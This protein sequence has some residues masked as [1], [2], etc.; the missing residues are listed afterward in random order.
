[1]VLLNSQM[2]FRKDARSSLFY[3]EFRYCIAWHIKHAHMLRVLNTAQIQQ[4]IHYRNGTTR[5][6][7][8]NSPVTEDQ[9]QTLLEACDYLNSRLNPYRKNVSTSHVWFYTNHPADF[10]RL[11]SFEGSRIESGTEA[12]VCLEPGVVTLTRPQHEYRTYFKERWLGSDQLSTIIR[13][14][15]SRATQFRLSPGFRMLV[16]GQRIWMT[17]N[18]FVDHNEPHADFLINLACPGIVRKTLPIVARG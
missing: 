9:A 15:G 10:D 1:M 13:Y 8:R 3:N 2:K 11:E 6:L 4:R 17:A 7:Y 5:D 18:H 14:F 16:E 12:D